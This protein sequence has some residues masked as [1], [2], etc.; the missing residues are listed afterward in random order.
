MLSIR[1]LARKELEPIFELK[2]HK[3]DEL[4]KTLY[5]FLMN[6]GNLQQSISDLSLSMSGLMYRITR[7][8]KLLGKELRNPTVAY[9][10]LLMLDALKILGDIDV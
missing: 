6:G 10:L 8:E 5:V 3:R 2:D 9:E 7:I 1:R 4:L